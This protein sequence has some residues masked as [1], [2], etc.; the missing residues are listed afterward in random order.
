MAEQ[1]V[2]ALQKRR[3]EFEDSD[4]QLL[5]VIATDMGRN[6]EPARTSQRTIAD[7]AGCHHNTVSGRIKNLA[8]RGVVGVIKHGRQ[9]FHTVPII[10][11]DCHKPS[12]DNHNP[13]EVDSDNQDNRHNSSQFVTVTDYHNFKAEVC[14]NL[15][16]LSDKIDALTE[17]LSQLSS[18]IVTI[19]QRVIVIE[20]KIEVIQ[21]TPQ[22][23]QGEN[24]RQHETNGNNRKRKQPLLII[25]PEMLDVPEFRA[26]WEKWRIYRG[27]K[28]KDSTY[29]E[30]L[31]K[32][33]KEPVVFAIARLERSRLNGWTGLWFPDEKPL[34]VNGLT[35]A[36]WGTRQTNGTVNGATKIDHFEIVL[37]A[38]ADRTVAELDQTYK[39]AI[40]A[41][42][43]VKVIQT[44][45]ADKDSFMRRDFNNLMEGYLNG[46]SH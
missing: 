32:L 6:D 9:Y 29:Q 13:P 42:G 19:H 11:T 44:R 18:Q 23:P 2:R 22:P 33:A 41:M 8:G 5:L 1:H 21:N 37:R 36:Q 4:F 25:I 35:A 43:G 24:E 20:D 40:N 34:L 17:Q 16:K 7:R 28:I 15:K 26:E 45:P 39:R 38:M 27:K 14:D 46:Q 10:I 12:Q 3:S 30:Q 31:D